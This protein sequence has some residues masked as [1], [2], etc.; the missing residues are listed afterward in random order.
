M[1]D[2]AQNKKKEGRAGKRLFPILFMLV[3][4]LV[5]ISITSVIYMVT[6]DTIKLNE[7]IKLKRAVLESGGIA[8]PEDPREVDGLYNS[9]V[10]EVSAAGELL[11][12]V[13]SPD[14]SAV[15]S[16]VLNITGPGLWGDITCIIG[17]DSRLE[18]CTGFEVIDQNETPGLGG[19]ISEKWFKD[20]F[21]GKKPPLISVAEGDETDE[22]EFQAITGAT[23]STAAVEYIMNTGLERV[24][25]AFKDE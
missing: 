5:F 4:T 18:T 14:G 12:E 25:V 1:S 19:R 6:K 9:R 24:K 20:Q 17:Y 16:Y 10:R 22:G 15:Q 2:A 23:Y 3:I 11:Y 13:T 8:A 7:T 21:I